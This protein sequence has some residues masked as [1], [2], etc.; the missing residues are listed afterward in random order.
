M[1]SLDI[2]NIEVIH[3]KIVHIMQAIKKDKENT[4]I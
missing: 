3:E 1:D 4:G 2:K